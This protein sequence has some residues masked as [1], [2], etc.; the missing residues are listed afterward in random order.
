MVINTKVLIR[1]IKD[2]E[3]ENILFPVEIVIKVHG[4]KVNAKE[5]EYINQL[6]EV[7]ILVSFQ[8]DKNQD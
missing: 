3:K 2:M 1:I 8:K 5:M 7:I 4:M 6:M